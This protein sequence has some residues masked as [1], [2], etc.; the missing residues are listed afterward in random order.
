MTL[1]KR[2]TDLLPPNV[3]DLS[4]TVAPWWVAHV[5]SRQEKALTRHLARSGVP[6]YLP[7]HEK[8][9]R[10]AGRRFLSYLPLFPGYVFCR[11]NGAERVVALQTHLVCQFLEVH[12]QRLLT[13]ELTQ[14]RLLQSSGA[15]LVPHVP[16]AP[17]DSVR[18]AQ[19]PF[20]GYVGVVARSGG[21]LR[22]VVSISMLRKAVA[23]EFDRAALAP[24]PMGF[25]PAV[26]TRRELTA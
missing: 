6:F 13:Q 19:G 5:R 7:L 25:R 1:L 16:L 22:L 20:Q 8:S 14:L 26:A 23:V 4:E 9:V 21:R 18:I 17:G 15:Q 12:E 24:V 11:G 2:E 10:R 3:L